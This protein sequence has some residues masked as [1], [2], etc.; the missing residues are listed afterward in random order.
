MVNIKDFKTKQEKYEGDRLIHIFNRQK[1]LMKK[2]HLIEKKNGLIITEDVPVNL[3]DPKG[4]ARLK[5]FAWR[6]TEELGEA[7]EALDK[8]PNIEDHYNEEIADA[9]H[10]LTEFTILAGLGPE[11][12]VENLRCNDPKNYLVTLYN[13]ARKK[14]L[15]DPYVVIYRSYDNLTYLTGHIIEKLAMTCNT[16]KQKPW[17]QTHMLTDIKLFKWCLKFTWIAFIELCIAAD[18]DKEKLFE[19]YL[20]KNKVNKFRIRSKY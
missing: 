3:N 14:V 9:L 15:E 2:Y 10:F 13:C 7:L 17:K 1:E 4:Q 16:L 6:I 20:G 11:D 8:H 18:I 19:L 12:L 5:D